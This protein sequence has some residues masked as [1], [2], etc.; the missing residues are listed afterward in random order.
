MKPIGVYIHVPFC[1]QKCPYCDFYSLTDLQRMDD[2][3]A[4]V[5]KQIE[6]YGERLQRQ[7]DTLYFGGGTPSVLGAQRLCRIIDAVRKQ[8]GLHGAEI[9]VEVNPGAEL[10]G[11]FAALAERGVNRV[12]VGMQSAQEQELRLLGRTHTAVQA[13]EAVT[14]AHRAGIDNVSMDLMAGISRQT[15]ES[16]KDSALFCAESGA[17]HISA[18]LL[19]IEPETPYG[20]RREQLVLP[21]DD[22]TG[23]LYLCMVEELERLGYTQYEISNFAGKG[24]DGALRTSRHNLKYWLCEEYL[25][26]GPAAHSFLQGERFYFSRNLVA[27]LNGEEPIFDGVGG[28]REEFA[29]LALRLTQGLTETLW[30]E[31]FGQAMPQKYYRWARKY[32]AAGLVHVTGAGFSLT[33]QGFLVSNL[34]LGEL[35]A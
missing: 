24:A 20:K 6:Q 2:Y 11:L 30:Q 16:L 34:L 35:L 25:G 12:S 14:A 7:A 9:T 32:Q 8:F 17:S 23:D 5:I 10:D 19:K 21:D 3:T 28:D 18:Y 22:E 15:Q 26:L 31:R 1:T 4:S 33:P 13:R 29:M 27:F